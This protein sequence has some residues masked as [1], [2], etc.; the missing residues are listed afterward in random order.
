MHLLHAPY[1]RFGNLPN[2]HSPLCN[3]VKFYQNYAIST[4][5]YWTKTLLNTGCVDVSPASFLEM[6]KK[7]KY[8]NCFVFARGAIGD[9]MWCMPICKAIKENHPGCYIVVS[10]DPKAVSVWR[11]VPYVDHLVPDT[12]STINAVVKTC[13]QVFD[14]SGIATCIPKYKNMDPIDA[15]FDIAGLE[16]YKEKDRMRPHLVC[17]ADEGM[18]MQAKLMLEKVNVKTDKIVSIA[19]ETSTPNRNYPK[20]H[21]LDLTKRLILS[22][23]KVVWLGESKD[24]GQYEK[25]SE[26]EKGCCVDF[27]GKISLREAMAVIN[28]SDCVVTQNSSLLIIAASLNIPQVTL[29]GAFSFKQRVKYYEK[30]HVIQGAACG[31]QCNEHWTECMYGHPAP[32]MRSITPDKVIIATK[33]M[34]MKFPR[35]AE[36]RM[37]VE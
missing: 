27:V 22:G 14:F 19:V 29:F 16:P 32:C 2:G 21:I 25:L 15:T 31:K 12:Y 13:D 34:M 6:R 20:E 11:Y 9:S 1:S 33:A 24:F 8:K 4:K 37:A 28:L 7:I 10:P 23:I 17:T 30:I 3:E 35:N 5:Q 36:A 26:Y 18:Q